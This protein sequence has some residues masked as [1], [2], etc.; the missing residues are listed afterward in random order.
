MSALLDLPSL[1]SNPVDD[2]LNGMTLW[3]IKG[4]T[5]GALESLQTNLTWWMSDTAYSVNFGGKDEGGV[6]NALREHTNLFT[7]LGA[8]AGFLVA[9]FRVA[10]QRKGEPLREAIAHF[11]ELAVIVFTLATAVNLASIASDRYSTWLL[12]DLAPKNGDWTANWTSN[13]NWFNGSG[14]MFL[15]G[16]FAIA[17]LISSLVQF[18]L[19]LF[20]SG[21]LI[22]LVGTLPA[23]AATRFTSYGNR[24][25]KKSVGWLISWIL[26]KPVAAT[27]YAAALSLMQSGSKADRL[28]GLALVGGAIFALPATL[29]AVMPSVVE[30]NSFFGVRQVGHF[31]FGGSALNAVRGDNVVTGARQGG[32]RLRRALFGP[33]GGNTT[34][35]GNPG[36]PGPGA[37]GSGV[38]RGGTPGPGTPGPGTPGPSVPWPGATPR[39]SAPGT[40]A[41]GAGGAPMTSGAPGTPGTSGR[42]GNSTT[43]GAGT[44]TGGAVPGRSTQNFPGY[45]GPSGAP[46]WGGPRDVADGVR[47]PVDGWGARDFQAPV[48]SVNSNQNTNSRIIIPR[49]GSS[50]PSGNDGTGRSSGGGGEG[51]S[52]PPGNP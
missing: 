10:I 7:T 47:G 4:V 40:G 18:V 45:T 12:Q 37:R 23:V 17:A 51:N 11:F 25:Y 41:P 9:A 39:P 27:I 6:L 48:E 31:I 34:T 50:G 3:F 1:G 49:N 43:G 5:K 32:Q 42:A 28:F 16:I 19:M 21:A 24:A 35:A 33:T 14:T 8:M 29:R 52:G 46:V 15:L 44:S 26:F 38:P 22:I 13:L 2:I 30:D 36:T 20:R